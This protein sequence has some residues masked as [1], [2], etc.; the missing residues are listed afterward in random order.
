MKTQHDTLTQQMSYLR[1]DTEDRD[2]GWHR[3]MSG[4][5]DVSK[6]G[7]QAFRPDG[8][9]GDGVEVQ[10]GREAEDDRPVLV[11]P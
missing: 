10:G 2:G 11:H 6:T 4:D 8:Q 7:L 9:P 1:A 5:G 3:E